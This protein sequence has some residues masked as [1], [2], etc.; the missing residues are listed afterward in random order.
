M[1]DDPVDV[2]GA[3]LKKLG[4]SINTRSAGD[5]RAAQAEA[6]RQKPLLRAYL[7][8]EARDQVVAGDI[9][10]AQMW[11]TT[12]QQALDASKDLAF[13]FP[14]EG[15]AVY[16]DCA[17][18]LRESGR[19]ELAHQFLNYLLRPEVAAAIVNA[20]KTATANG[21]ARAL[22]PP[23]IRDNQTLYPSAETMRRGEWSQASPPEIQRLRDRLWTEVKSS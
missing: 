9:S 18:I 3:C 22:L 2:F 15:F 8:A 11:S 7:N 12:A 20:V 14:K 6:I 4:K 23:A 10:A 1:L 16:P 5:L 21:A 19:T 13:V 17:V